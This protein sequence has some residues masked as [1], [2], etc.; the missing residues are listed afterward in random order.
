MARK[1]SKRSYGTGSI[2]QRG[3]GLVIRWREKE[4]ASDGSTHIVHRCETVGDIPRLEAAARLRDRLAGAAE[5]KATP[6]TFAEFAI[7]WKVLVLPKYPKHSTRKHHAD[8]LEDKLVP[9]F[10]HLRVDEITGEH[11]QRFVQAMEDHGYAPH[12]VH[13]YHSVLSAVL[14]RAVKWKR[15]ERNAALGARLP[16]LKAKRDQWV[17]TYA[18]AWRLLE[19]LPV[20]PRFVVYLALTTGLRR[21]ELFALRWMDFNENAASLAI[22]QAVYDGIVDSPKTTKSVRSIPLA[23]GAVKVLQECQSV[24]KRTKPQDFIFAGRLG[25]PGDSARMLRDHIQPA[26][27]RLGLKQHGLLFVGRGPHGPTIRTSVRRFVGN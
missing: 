6:V 16:Q 3:R 17:L 12:S 27:E 10:G 8:I 7:Q 19:A 13:H 15:I 22:V 25:V 1:H 26:C 9:F 18:Q 14:S 21:G 20:R 4:I 2:Q 24:S 11:V 23:P 5:P